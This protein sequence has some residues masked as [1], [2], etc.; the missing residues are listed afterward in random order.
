M[1]PKKH[2]IN[3]VLFEEI[4]KKGKTFPFKYLSLRIA[5]LSTP[6]ETGFLRN[7]SALKESLSL[8]GST[9]ISLFAFVAS[10]K[11]SKKSVIRNKLKKR[12]RHIIKKLLPKIKS[13]LGAIIFFKSGSEKLTFHELGKVL[14]ESLKKTKIL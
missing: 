6:L 7:P 5:S 12:A 8:T 13:G 4:F 9:P 14:Q 1:L 3:K 11:V 10:Q 2:R